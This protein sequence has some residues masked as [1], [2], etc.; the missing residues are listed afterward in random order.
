MQYTKIAWDKVAKQLLSSVTVKLCS[1]INPHASDTKKEVSWFRVLLILSLQF[2]ELI[3]PVPL[4]DVLIRVNGSPAQALEEVKL[5]E[6]L[7]YWV[8]IIVV[9]SEQK[10]FKSER[11]KFTE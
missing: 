1:G 6:G 10:S 5:G 2:Q 8:T 4:I 11:N 3:W 9:S 7:Q